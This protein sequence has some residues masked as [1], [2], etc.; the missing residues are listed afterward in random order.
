MTH[1]TNFN[2]SQWAKSDR[3]RMADFNAD[4]AKIDAA[5]LARNCRCYCMSYTGDGGKSRTFTFPGKPLMVNLL[6]DIALIVLNRGLNAGSAYWGAGS[7]F[8]LSVVWGE[9]SVTVTHDSSPAAI[10]NN[11]GGSFGLFAILE[12]D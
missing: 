10:A 8:K 11:S 3:I 12:A 9:N 7:Y 1:T 5:L 2:L 6:S 4:N